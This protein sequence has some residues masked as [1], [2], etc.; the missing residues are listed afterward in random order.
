MDGYKGIFAGDSDEAML[1]EAVRG[2][3]SAIEDYDKALTETM[4]PP[5]LKEIIR[6]QREKLHNDIQTTEILEDYR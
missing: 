6:T 4:M 5:R 1:E 2:D 3:K